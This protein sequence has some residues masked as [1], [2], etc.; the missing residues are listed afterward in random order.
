MISVRDFNQATRRN[1]IGDGDDDTSSDDSGSNSSGLTADENAAFAE[2][3]NAP[4]TQTYAPQ[5]AVQAGGSLQGGA[6][7]DEENAAFAQDWNSP[8]TQAY[9]QQQAIQQGGSLEGGP[10]ASSSQ[11]AKSSSGGFQASPGSSGN[12]VLP[13]APSSS[14]QNTSGDLA[15]LIKSLSPAA[16]AGAQAGLQLT[17]KKSAASPAVASTSWPN[18]SSMSTTTKVVLGIAA[19]G[20]VGGGIYLATRKKAST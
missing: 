16:A 13:G 20:F 14:G 7:T 9:Q 6:L 17:G 10:A 5:Q 12:Q 15:S 19:V 8:V 18:F 3:W 2:D 1:G 11:A 4:A